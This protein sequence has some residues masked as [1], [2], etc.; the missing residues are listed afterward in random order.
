MS[1]LARKKFVC[2]GRRDCKKWSQISMRM[3]FFTSRIQCNGI[4]LKKPRQRFLDAF[5]DSFFN[6]FEETIV[7]IERISRG[8][9]REVDLSSKAEIREIKSTADALRADMRVVLLEIKERK[10]EDKR[11]LEEQRRR[12]TEQHERE[13]RLRAV[14]GQDLQESLKALLFKHLR[15]GLIYVATLRPLSSGK[16]IDEGLRGLSKKLFPM[17]TSV[18]PGIQGPAFVKST[19]DVYV[20]GKNRVCG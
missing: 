4:Y 10:Q 2:I 18:G 16:A 11:H 5:N 14:H 7:N 6:S 13:E 1:L 9:L 15:D 19:E 17:L 20:Q 3:F 12:E 8:I